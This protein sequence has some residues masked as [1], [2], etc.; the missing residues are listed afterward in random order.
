MMHMKSR[1]KGRRSFLLELGGVSLSAAHS[2]V[3]VAAVW[4]HPVQRAVFVNAELDHGFSSAK[5]L[6]A[7]PNTVERIQGIQFRFIGS[8]NQN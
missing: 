1:V 3:S 4:F 5:S 6:N 8:S 2:I 7:E